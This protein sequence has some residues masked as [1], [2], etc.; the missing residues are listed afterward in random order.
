MEFL[1]SGMKLEPDEVTHL[2]I[3]R[4]LT[5][6]SLWYGITHGWRTSS[7][8]LTRHHQQSKRAICFSATGWSKHLLYTAVPAPKEGPF[9]SKWKQ[10]ENMLQKCIYVCGLKK[11]HSDAG[12]EG[13]VNMSNLDHTHTH[14]NNHSTPTQVHTYYQKHTCMHPWNDSQDTQD[15]TVAISPSS[16]RESLDI[17]HGWVLELNALRSDVSLMKCSKW[18]RNHSAAALPEHSAL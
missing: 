18:Y 15:Q 2:T 10:R 17:F 12:A 16:D 6:Q 7:T 1:G 14:K 3:S 8:T 5:P 13:W 4:E 9:S 11:N